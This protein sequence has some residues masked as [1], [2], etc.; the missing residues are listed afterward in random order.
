MKK[1][2]QLILAASVLV[3]GIAQAGLVTTIDS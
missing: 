2:L 1:K 3:G